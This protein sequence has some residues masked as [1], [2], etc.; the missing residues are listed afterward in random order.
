MQLF[1]NILVSIALLTQVVFAIEITENKVDRGTVTLNLG[2]ITIYPGASWSIID[3]AYTNFVGKL[4]VRDG[5]GL[6]ISSTSHLL[7]LQVSLTALLHSITNNGVVSFDSR[8]SR[9]SSSYDLRGVS[10]TNNGEMYFAASGEFSSP[11]ALTSASWTN[12]GL[13]SFYQNQ[14]TSGTVSLGMPLGSITNTGQVCLNNQV[15]EQTTQIKGSGCFTAN[16]DSTIYISNV[17]LAVS[18]KQNFY[19][20]DKG[21]SMI[22]QA[23]STT[24]TFN[25]Y[26]FGEGNKIGLT[27]PLMGNLWNSAYA[28]DTTSGILTL[29]NLLLEQKFNIGTG[30]DP[31]KF[32]VVTDSGSGIPSTILGSVAYYGRVPERTLPKS[33]QIPCKPIP[34]APGTTPTQYTTTI[35]KTNTAGNTVTESG[36]VN[37]STDKGG[38]WF[39]TTSIYP[40]ETSSVEEL[41]S[42]MSN[43][44]I[45]SAPTLSIETPVS[46]HHS[47]MQHSSFESSA[48]INTVFSSESAFETASDYIVSTPSSISH[49]TMVPQS[50][51]SALSVVSESLASAEPSFVVPSES[52]IFSASS[53]APQPSS[54][55]YSVSF[56]TQFETPSSAGPS[57]VTSVESNTEL[58]SSATQS[59]DIQTEFTSTW[60][61]TNSD[62]SVVTESG[63]ISQSGTSLTTL[64]TF[65]PA[66]SLV[67]PPYS[68]IE[69]EFTSTWTTT[70]SDSLV[71]TESG[72]VSQS[73]TLLTTVTTFPPAPSAIVPEFTSPWKINTSIESSETLTVSASSY[74][75][76]G[77]SLAAAT[78][79]Y[80]SSATV[81]VAPSESE[82]NT[83]S[84]ILNNEEIAS[85]PVSDTTSIAEHHDGSLSM[86]T[87]E[88]VNSN[89]LPSSHSIVTA[90]ITSCN[91]SKC[92]ESVVTY[93]SSVSCATITVG[94]SE[95]NISIVGNNVSSIVG[96][97]VSN[98][99][100]ITMA[101]STEGAT[102]L[103]SVSGAKPSVANDATN[104]VHTTDYTTA[105]AGV[106]NG[107]SLSIPSDVPIEISVI[108]PTNSSSSAVTISYENGS[109]KE[110]IE[111]I[112]YLALVVFGLMMFM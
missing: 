46:S 28:Y 86:T 23:V 77:E 12:T 71:A 27:I 66:T 106:Q 94:D 48:D 20:T 51:V 1:Q 37:V 92:S 35:T 43:W 80:L 10:F 98:T 26:G 72:V 40:I 83:S 61:T 108:T 89:S 58:I 4:D 64:T 59:S 81:V 68:V 53:A 73:D 103:T 52:F 65:Q 11:T 33:C 34:E 36:V 17:L 41:L 100:A 105:T 22:V 96:E 15:Y 104:S 24:Q 56:T 109:N 75:T 95:K 39:T 55:T 3:N 7:A 21:S 30:Y 19:L 8:I 45:S 14:R 5:A 101:T 93:V 25:V 107:S 13:L 79:S 6:Y 44:E 91:K 2:D 62:G 102:T 69:T 18:P 60:T 111:N 31:S 76:V 42:V 112:K 50:S 32:Q 88:F 97:D 63:I 9:T 29:R 87:T 38:S 82:I 57:L 90:T 67:V 47:S 49:S 78:S 110:S 16:G 70:N 99:Q 85:A 54:S 84:S 74:E